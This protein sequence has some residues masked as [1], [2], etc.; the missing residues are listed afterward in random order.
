VSPIYCKRCGATL[1][2]LAGM[3]QAGEPPTHQDEIGPF[4]R[5]PCCGDA[6]RDVGDG[7]LSQQPAKKLNEVIPAQ[8]PRPSDNE[9]PNANPTAE[10]DGSANA[11]GLPAG[12]ARWQRA[13]DCSGSRAPRLFRF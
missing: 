3:H 12:A 7:R 6:N 9:G 4:V 2:A 1:R 11:P 8:E 13:W 5:C 10:G